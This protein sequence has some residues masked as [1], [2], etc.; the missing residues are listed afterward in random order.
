MFKKILSSL[1]GE[2]ATQPAP[3]SAPAAADDTAAIFES[4]AMTDELREA[5]FPKSSQMI[6]A[7]FD[8]PAPL[9]RPASSSVAR[10][11]GHQDPLFL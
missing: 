6:S 11:G 2:S 10:P 9:Q 5:L 4:L 3:A 1:R 8:R 7:I